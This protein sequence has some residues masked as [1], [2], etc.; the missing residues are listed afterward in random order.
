MVLRTAD[1]ELKI[2]AC[3]RVTEVR[4]NTEPAEFSVPT[5]QGA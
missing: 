2:G 5:P 3:R 4:T 1:V